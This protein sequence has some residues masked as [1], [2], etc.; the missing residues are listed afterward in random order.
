MNGL[1][2][3]L[4]AFGKDSDEIDDGVSTCNRP[5]NGLRIPDIGLNGHDLAHNSHRLKMSRK[6]RPAHSGANPI[7]ALGQGADHMAS[8][9]ARSA[10]NGHELAGRR[11]HEVLPDATRR[12]SQPLRLCTGSFAPHCL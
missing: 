4:A 5:A 7:A 1:K 9:E 8:D 6:V 10:E 11:P 2:G 12:I 3:L